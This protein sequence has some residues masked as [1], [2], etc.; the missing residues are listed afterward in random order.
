MKPIL[1]YLLT[2]NTKTVK[3]NEYD[4]FLKLLESNADNS[5]KKEH[6]EFFK[7]WSKLY[8]KS[9]VDALCEL[10]NNF[11]DINTEMIIG[12]DQPRPKTKKSFYI[13]AD[14]D[15]EFKMTS[16][17]FYDHIGLNAL[18]VTFTPEETCVYFCHEYN[19]NDWLSWLKDEEW[20]PEKF[21]SNGS[22]SGS[23]DDF[24]K[25]IDLIK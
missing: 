9:F 22:Y 12:Y 19:D 2:K 1:E 14:G 25:A 18:K 8:D 17:G 10:I 13:T 16:F 15:S 23:L 3:S 24:K 6:V 5:E 11:V 20:P 7:K 21:I 4:D